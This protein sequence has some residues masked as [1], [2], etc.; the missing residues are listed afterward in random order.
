MEETSVGIAASAAVASGAEWVDLDGSLLLADD[1]FEGLQLDPEHRW[2][3]TN[4]P[5]LGVRRRG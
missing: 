5:G 1:P 2:Q 4:E 3:L